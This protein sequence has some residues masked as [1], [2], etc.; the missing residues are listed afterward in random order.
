MGNFVINL[1]P[2]NTRL[3][4]DSISART[5]SDP[6]IDD[7]PTVLPGTH[8]RLGLRVA[9][10]AALGALVPALF[11]ITFRGN[12]HTLDAII[13]SALGSIGAA[14]S[15][16]F[17]VRHALAR[18]G[19]VERFFERRLE[20]T[21][22]LVRRAEET[23]R[24]ERAMASALESNAAQLE[25]RLTE[26]AVFF[27]ALRESVTTR[28]LDSVLRTIVDRIGPTLRCREATVFL[29][30]A[31]DRLVIRAAWGFDEPTA[32]VGRT[33]RVGEGILGRSAADQRTIDV[34]DLESYEDDFAFLGDDVEKT[35]SYMSVPIAFQG[36]LIGLLA[37]TRPPCDELTEGEKRFV[38][39]LADQAALAIQNAQLFAELQR[40]ST[41]DSLTGLPNRRLFEQRLVQCSMESERYGHELAVLAIDVD[42]FKLINDHCGH[43]AGD[44]VLVGLAETL[45]AGVRSVD[46]V[47]RIGG[48]E[49]SVL[50]TR[51]SLDSALSVAE[52]LRRRVQNMELPAGA[53]QPLGRLSI[54]V[55][56]A[57]WQTGDTV[58]SL[59]DR[60][61]RALYQSKHLGR[62]RVSTQPPYRE[63]LSASR[64]SSSA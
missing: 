44:S 40:L 50:L 39:A 41:H 22:S 12:V 2:R 43:P 53:R 27:D 30:E 58:E 7:T 37:L 63:S 25:Q 49:F 10:W 21:S 19:A 42:H 28:D 16:F 57:A 51:A 33:V 26:L 48:E 59:T 46:T 20:A 14:S 56:V 62:N 29:K 24:R 60:A 5:S 47:A 52:D 54:S 64:R 34:P 35:G 31:E 15:T 4:G 11:L 38:A 17:A 18:V 23:G 6:S 45:S 13:A 55:G 32:V 3:R 9:G 36:T 8:D 1:S 61:D